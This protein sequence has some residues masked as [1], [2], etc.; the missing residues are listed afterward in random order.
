LKS[1]IPRANDTG[2]FAAYDDLLARDHTGH[3]ALLTD[4]DLRRLHIA[5][6]LAIDL[7]GAAANYLLGTPNNIPFPCRKRRLSFG[8]S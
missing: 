4:D 6:D 3:L 2:D 1:D 7:K 5:L 8:L